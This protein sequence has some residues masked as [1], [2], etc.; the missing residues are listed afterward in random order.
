MN[1]LLQPIAD[2]RRHPIRVSAQE[3]SLALVKEK[4]RP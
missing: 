3:T 4:T 2:F 1:I